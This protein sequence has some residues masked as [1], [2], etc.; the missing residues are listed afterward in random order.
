LRA[1]LQAQA[2]DQ[3]WPAL[4]ARLAGLDPEAADRIHPNDPQRIQRALEVHALTGLS[5]SEWWRRQAGEASGYAIHKVVLCPAERGELHQRAERRFGDML[6]AGFLGEV[7]RL[8]ARG[9]L[10][11]ELPSMRVVGYRQAWRYLE[12][13]LDRAAMVGAAV[14]ATRQLAKRQLTW[15]RREEGAA[16]LDSCDR[17]HI[18]E[19]RHRA[20][21]ILHRHVNI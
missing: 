6:N 14:A 8:H 3:G 5:L 15:L 17:H 11:P 18:D 9:D 21:H 2:A 10:N 4:H 19:L 7:E 12:G 20:E 16:W 1:R 13:G